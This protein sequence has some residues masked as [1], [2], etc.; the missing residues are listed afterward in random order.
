MTIKVQDDVAAEAA[1]DRS[2]FFADDDDDC[3]GFFCD[4]KCRA[5]TRTETRIENLCFGHRK[6]D[7]RARNLQVANEYRAVMEFVDGLRDKHADEQLA[8]HDRLDRNA[9]AFA[10]LEHV[11]V[12]LEGD[13]RTHAMPSEF[14]CSSNDFFDDA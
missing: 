6:E 10:E 1:T 5:M 11:G 3:I 14:G 9:F 7:A 2:A 4:A 12:L 13:D 8:R